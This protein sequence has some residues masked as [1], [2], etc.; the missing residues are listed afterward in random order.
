MR[1]VSSPRTRTWL[2]LGF[3]LTFACAGFALTFGFEGEIANYRYGAEGWPRVLFIG[4]VAAAAVQAWA[5]FGRLQPE[6]TELNARTDPAADV[7]TTRPAG[8]P[9]PTIAV[10]VAYVAL[11][12]PVGFFVATPP[13]L[14]GI[15]LSMGERRLKR[16]ILV[17][18]LIYGLIVLVFVRLLYV[19]LPVGSW[20][21]FYDVGNWLL[22]AVR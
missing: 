16:I 18:A 11:L 1:A 20:P 14:A 19:P 10:C 3:W 7:A 8:L 15:M 9:V 6:A 13:F 4:I 17:T 22:T 2:E 12:V 21:G 5:T